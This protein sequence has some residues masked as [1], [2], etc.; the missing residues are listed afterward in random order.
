ML[1]K[2]ILPHIS[3]TEFVRKYQI[4]RWQFDANAIAPNKFLAPRP[5]HSLTFYIRDLQSFSF[6]NSTKKEYYP[7][8]IISGIHDTTLIR[9]C[10]HDFWALKII[11][12]PCALFRLTGFP[13]TELVS[14]YVDAEIVW[15]KE[16]NL[17]HQRLNSSDNLNDMVAN[18]SFYLNRLISNTKK[19]FHPVDFV[20]Q[21]ILFQKEH[22]NLD[23]LAKQSFLSTRQ[24]IRKFE[25]RTGVSPKLYDKIVRFD[26]AYRLKNNQPDLDWLSIAMSSG[27]Y[28]YQH[29]A[30]DYKDFTNFTPV[31]Y[32][33]IDKKAPER[34]FGLHFG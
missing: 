8:S 18:I 3:L 22:K 28:D 30:K 17:L 10:G 29:L 5:E 13:M 12:Q 2:D 27:Y 1:I 16:I 11:F 6:I 19:D 14:N 32:Y 7:K 23:L 21:E 20:C 24:F 9:D 15:G 33:E 31:A 26:K 34:N 25:E 4:I